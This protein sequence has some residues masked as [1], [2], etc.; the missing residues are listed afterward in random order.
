MI[1]LFVSSSQNIIEK[2]FLLETCRTEVIAM[3]WVKTNIP[4]LEVTLS[5]WTTIETHFFLN[6]L[7]SL[8][9]QLDAFINTLPNYRHYRQYLLRDLPVFLTLY[10]LIVSIIIIDA[11]SNPYIQF[12][13]FKNTEIVKHRISLS[14]E[15]MAQL[16]SQCCVNSTGISSRIVHKIVRY[17]N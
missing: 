12:W 13:V 14:V 7:Q 17:T 9:T 15:S 5:T 4:S 1:N 8:H 16:L 10:S 6:A 3:F 2:Q 11:N